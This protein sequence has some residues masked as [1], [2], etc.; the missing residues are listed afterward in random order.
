[1]GMVFVVVGKPTW[2]AFEH[3]AR[4]GKVSEV[5]IIALEGLT[6]ASAI[7]FDSGEYRTA[8]TA[9]APPREERIRS[10]SPP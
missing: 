7:P 10:D 4:V 3:G 5:G 8:P 6:K 2:Q 1:M 9:A